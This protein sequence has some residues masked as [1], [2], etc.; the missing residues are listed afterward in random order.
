MLTYYRVFNYEDLR[1]QISSTR[2]K[3]MTING[4]IGKLKSTTDL[5]LKNLMMVV[6]EMKSKPNIDAVKLANSTHQMDAKMRD[7]NSQVLLLRQ[8]MSTDKE[9]RLKQ[10]KWSS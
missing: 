4:E 9:E 10:E 6:Q 2:E 1:Q 8:T 7:L 5:Q 3:I